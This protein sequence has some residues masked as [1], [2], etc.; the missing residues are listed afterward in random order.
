VTD[1]V[2][3]TGL[4]S[5][6]PNLER[7]PTTIGKVGEHVVNEE[8]AA[9]RYLRYPVFVVGMSRFVAMT[10]VDEQQREWRIPV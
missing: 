3:R 8:Q 2:E 6:G 4:Y 5:S 9:N 10:T 7:W 1:L